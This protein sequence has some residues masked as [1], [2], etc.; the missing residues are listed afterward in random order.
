MTSSVNHLQF[1]INYENVGFY[2]ILLKFLGWE[3][4]GDWDGIIGFKNGASATLW[5]SKTT[6]QVANNR[7]GDGLNHIG[8]IVGSVAQV[9]ETVKFLKKEN[10]TLL[11]D[12][13][14]HRPEFSDEAGT[15]YQ[16]MFDSPDK[17]LFEVMYTGPK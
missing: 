12:T 10:V 6:K 8:I 5:F 17:I 9:D 7:D 16:V 1:N 4:I 14:K 2:K 15:Y 13:P 11:Y 3:I